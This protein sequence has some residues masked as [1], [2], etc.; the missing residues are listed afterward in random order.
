M[1]KNVKFIKK[2]NPT[3]CYVCEGT[4][5][6]VGPGVRRKEAL[7]HPCKVCKGTGKWNEDTYDCIATQPDGQKIAFRVDGIK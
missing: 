6:M 2:S 5:F 7:K 4:G 3:P 1:A